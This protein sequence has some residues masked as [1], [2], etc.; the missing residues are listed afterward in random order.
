MAV[1]CVPRISLPNIK[2]V[3]GILVWGGTPPY[4]V[5]V[6]WN[7]GADSTL[8]SVASA[9][10]KTVA[11][12]YA[13]P[14]TYKINLRLKD[15]TDKEAVVETAVQIY[16]GTSTETNSDIT[17]GSGNSTNIGANMAS[18]IVEVVSSGWFE[19]PVPF[20]LLA[21]AVTLGFWFGDIFDRRY[22]NQVNRKRRTA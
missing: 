3:M 10:Y 4:A 6:N 19:T 1:V 8:I 21:V 22:N 16:S 12:N 18:A 20:Y 9:G 2:Q 11:Y 5:S 7:D 14:K 17:S 13:V 15:H